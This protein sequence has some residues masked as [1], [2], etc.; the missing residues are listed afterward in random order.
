METR[1]PKKVAIKSPGFNIIEE[2]TIDEN[3]SAHSSITRHV[4]TDSIMQKQNGTGAVSCKADPPETTHE[5][6]SLPEKSKSDT[7]SDVTKPDSMPSNETATEIVQ[8]T[9]QHKCKR[10]AI[11]HL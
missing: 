1:L 11:T 3:I 6:V 5:H 7:A 4:V 9:S 10:P 2:Y 8:H